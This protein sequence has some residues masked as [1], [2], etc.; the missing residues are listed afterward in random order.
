[1]Q[2]LILA[3]FLKRGLVHNLSDENEFYLHVN[4]NLFSYEKLRTK[5]HSEKEV[6]L[7]NDLFCVTCHCSTNP[8][9]SWQPYP[10]RHFSQI[11]N[12][13]VLNKNLLFHLANLY[14]LISYER[15]SVNCSGFWRFWKKPEIQDGWSKMVLLSTLEVL[16]PYL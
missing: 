7:G 3:D 16:L 2:Y 12:F 9:L 6:Q 5:T 15:S 13:T 1:M 8:T 14:I 11:L 4:E 10:D